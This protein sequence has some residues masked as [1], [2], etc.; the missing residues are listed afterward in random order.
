MPTIRIVVVAL[1]LSGLSGGCGGTPAVTTVAGSSH[2]GTVFVI[3]GGKGRVELVVERAA[4]SSR[5]PKKSTGDRIAAYFLQGDGV[6]PMSPPPSEVTLK[7]GGNDA[8]KPIVLS[9]ASGE[10]G[11]FVS[12]PGSF[13]DDL[14]G[15][16]SANIAGSAVTI[17][18]SSR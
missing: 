8:S 13:G 12:E 14:R 15:E 7:L 5:T 6:S 3:P 2:N 10:A 4:N 18:I 17:P 11:K 16:L 9:P 1:L